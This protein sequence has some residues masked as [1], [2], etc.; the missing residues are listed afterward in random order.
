[1]QEAECFDDASFHGAL[2]PPKPLWQTYAMREIILAMAEPD[3]K[4]R[5]FQFQLVELCVL[6]ALIA[7]C[8]ALYRALRSPAT[9]AQLIASVCA[10]VFIA[11]TSIATVAVLPWKGLRR[12]LF[13][14]ALFGWMYLL[15]LLWT[16][17]N[18]GSVSNA[19][20]FAS[21]L[22][23]GLAIGVLATLAAHLC[24]PRFDQ[25]R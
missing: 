21:H 16:F 18:I 24:L 8:A 6:V 5:W 7:G 25:A 11:L 15:F 4:R 9:N 1:M 3:S 20:H 14:F 12:P 17:D 10:G 23:F 13:V 22:K 19:T 2:W